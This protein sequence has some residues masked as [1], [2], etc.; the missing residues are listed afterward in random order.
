MKPALELPLYLALY[1]PSVDIRIASPAPHIPRPRSGF[2][3]NTSKVSA[4]PIDFRS[5]V[6]STNFVRVFQLRLGMR[7]NHQQ[8]HRRRLKRKHDLHQL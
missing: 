6:L 2:N 8:L 1:R 4:D 5:V 3:W 7:V